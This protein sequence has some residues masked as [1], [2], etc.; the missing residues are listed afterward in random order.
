MS[1][2]WTMEGLL[3]L[4]EKQSL[5]RNLWNRFSVPQ[6]E[7]FPL[8]L[9]E[10]TY[11]SIS[12]TRACGCISQLMLASRLPQS[13]LASFLALPSPPPT[14][15]P[16]YNHYF[17][18]PLWL[19]LAIPT[20]LALA[21]SILFL[22]LSALDSSRCLWLP[23]FLSSIKTVPLVEQLFQYFTAPLCIHRGI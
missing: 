10:G 17:L 6:K 13:T 21:M 23:S 5:L 3:V 22:F 12:L 8:P 7:S 9:A 11:G 14:T 15:Y 19:S 4:K 1:T 2:S 20:S 16:P 18:F